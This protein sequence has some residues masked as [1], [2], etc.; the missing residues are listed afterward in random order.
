[1]KINEEG[2]ITDISTEE[3]VAM[4]NGVFMDC[5]RARQCGKTRTIYN[6]MFAW[7]H[8]LSTLNEE[9]LI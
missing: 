4:L 5:P 3:A 1:M 2:Y 8:I 9:N 7:Q 6:Y